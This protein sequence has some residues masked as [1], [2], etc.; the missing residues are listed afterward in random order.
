[1]ILGSML[2]NV[3]ILFEFLCNELAFTLTLNMIKVFVVVLHF[4]FKQDIDSRP[5]MWM[6]NHPGGDVLWDCTGETICIEE[7]VMSLDCDS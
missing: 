5:H 2:S 1:M 7:A 4:G 3:W 6:C